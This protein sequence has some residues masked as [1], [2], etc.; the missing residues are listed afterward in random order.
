MEKWT[1]NKEWRALKVR[2][3]L[4]LGVLGGVVSSPAGSGAE[5]QPPTHFRALEIK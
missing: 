3:L 2:C 5:P 4:R 1:R